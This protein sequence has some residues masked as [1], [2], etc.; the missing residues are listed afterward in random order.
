MGDLLTRG[1]KT[2]AR[3]AIK[4]YRGV[5]STSTLPARRITRPLIR[6][7]AK[8]GDAGAL[9]KMLRSDQVEGSTV[10][11]KSVLV[12]LLPLRDPIVAPM[13]MQLTD[14]DPDLGVRKLA[15]GVLAAL[16][17]RRTVPFLVGTLRRTS[18]NTIKVHA[19]KGLANS[20]VNEAVHP[21][22]DALDDP[23]GAVRMAAARALADIGDIAAIPAIEAALRRTRNPL[24]RT[25]LKMALE[26]LR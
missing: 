25:S 22:I 14:R 1:E 26:R 9:L 2:Q 16:G 18:D 24:F 19:M 7:V 3:P 21:L 5:S 12:N 23:S 10:L 8:R 4:R 15:M 17:D 6:S 13:M 20:R 11:R